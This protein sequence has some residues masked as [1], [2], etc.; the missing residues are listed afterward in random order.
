[1]AG[2][3]NEVKPC[4]NFYKYACGNWEKTNPSLNQFIHLE[5]EKMYLLKAIL[6]SNWNENDNSAVIKAKKL[7][8]A[9][10]DTNTIEKQGLSRLIYL[11]NLIGG[12][13]LTMSDNE[14][15]IK[16]KSWQIIDQ[17]IHKI[18]GDS[19]LF[20]IRAVIDNS[21]TSAHI[22]ALSSPR[23]KPPA[24][25]VSIIDPI[26]M[27]LEPVV[28]YRNLIANI[29]KI[30]ANK[31]GTFIDLNTF[32]ND[33]KD[34]VKF[35]VELDQIAM[36]ETKSTTSDV[37]QTLEKITIKQLQK[38]YDLS[39]NKTIQQI[40]WLYRIQNIMGV[41]KIKVEKSTVVA[42]FPKQYF[43]KLAKLLSKT[44]PKVIINLVNW[45]MVKQLLRHTNKE[46]SDLV[47]QL[48]EFEGIED[49]PR[50]F[51]CTSINEMQ[52]ALAYE[53]VKKYFPNITSKNIVK[54]IMQQ[55]I[56]EMKNNIVNSTWLDNNS[57]QS[58]LKKLYNMKQFIGYPDWYN[59]N[60][61][62]FFISRWIADPTQVNAFYYY[63]GNA[64]S[65]IIG[66]EI[67]HGFDDVGRQYDEDGNLRN[68]WSTDT[69]N[70]Y[71]DRAECFVHK[72]G[73]YVV[74]YHNISYRTDPI[75]T[76]SENIADSTGVRAVFEAF[77]KH[78]AEFPSKNMRLPGL[79]HLNTRQL[80]FLSYAHT[81]CEAIPA[82]K[83]L[84]MMISNVHCPST[85]RIAGTLSNMEDFAETF[86]CKPGTV[87]NPTLKCGIWY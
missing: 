59:D 54:D 46:M 36:I 10:M 64:L 61:I 40:N 45:W 55:I 24:G 80:F 43:T 87:M 85:F 7:Y 82:E 53:Y 25:F 52:H 16:N 2:M 13:P 21:N 81:F 42:V 32:D 77:K 66:H 9:C 18:M 68:W 31:Q 19:A 34:I 49:K 38:E 58:A 84:N 26:D 50:W 27:D 70:E 17:T 41:S 15:Q 28:N 29:T 48:E 30:I 56:T 72:F 23:P 83:M 3:K 65:N 60:N 67:S 74:K 12:W 76:L 71:N 78:S 44:P 73:Q 1:M 37:N 35:E 22:I 63:L 51:F 39:E 62:I 20:S 57:R 5:K 86:K 4:D 75:K 69:I 11:I 79:E 8:R 47:S 33:I 14:W 6:E